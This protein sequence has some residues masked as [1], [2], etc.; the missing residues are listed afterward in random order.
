MTSVAVVAV[1]ALCIAEGGD[2]L[3]TFVLR[4]ENNSECVLLKQGW[5]G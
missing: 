1:S 2:N 5:A 4:E 3:S